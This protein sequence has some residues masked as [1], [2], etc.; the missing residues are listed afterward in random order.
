M[1]VTTCVLTV[2]SLDLSNLEPFLASLVAFSLLDKRNGCNLAALILS[3]AAL[4]VGVV[5]LVVLQ[6]GVSNA[7][8]ARA[9]GHRDSKLGSAMLRG[10]DGSRGWPCDHGVR[11]EVAGSAALS[12]TRPYFPASK[13]PGA[14]SR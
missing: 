9:V 3:L 5:D 10:P 12:A 8:S 6:P 2:F 13:D 7:C 11:W 4:E 14:E 1:A